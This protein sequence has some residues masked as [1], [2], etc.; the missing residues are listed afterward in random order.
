MIDVAV[1]ARCKELHDKLEKA[2][3]QATSMFGVMDGDISGLLDLINLFYQ[4]YHSGRIY[5]AVYHGTG[6]YPH[7]DECV[8]GRNVIDFYPDGSWK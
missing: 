4:E 6:N 3:E 7:L 1:E 2:A 8:N 5:L